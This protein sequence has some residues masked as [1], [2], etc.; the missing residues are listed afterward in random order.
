MLKRIHIKGYKSFRNE[1]VRL[2]PLTAL[3]EASASGKSNFLDALDCY[4]YA[5]PMMLGRKL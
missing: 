5:G 4:C 1:E 3:L 2:E